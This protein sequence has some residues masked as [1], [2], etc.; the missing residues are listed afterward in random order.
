MSSLT[1]P[2]PLSAPLA[3]SGLF[4]LASLL[5]ACAQAPVP[6]SESDEISEPRGEDTGE[7]DVAES[8]DELFGNA[9]YGGDCSAGLKTFLDKIHF[10]GRVV[11]GSRAFEQCID[12]SLR[13]ATSS[14]YGGAFGEY[15][16]CN[17]DPYYGYSADV[18]RERV[19]EASRS[20]NDVF[21]YCTGGGGLASTN[22]GP[23]DTNNAE[24]LWWSGWLT[25]VYNSLGL[26]LCGPAQPAPCR[27]APDPW[28]YSQAA[29][30]VWHEA[31]H[32]HGYTHGANE[33]A[34]AL[35]A[36]GYSGD[37][38]WHF[39]VNT[40]PYIVGDCMS[41]VIDRSGM[42][43]G[44][45]ESCGSGMLKVVTG[46]GA[47]TCECVAD[48]RNIGTRSSGAFTHIV[49]A[50]NTSSATTTLDHPALNGNPSAK[51]QFTHVW[52]PPGGGTGYNGNR[53]I[54]WYN[55]ATARWVIQNSNGVSLPIG[56]GF[57]VR[58]GR[59]NVHRT[60]AANV[61]GHITY[62]DHP[63]ANGDPGAWVT[64]SPTPYAGAAGGN[65]NAHSI[66]VYYDPGVKKW[67]IY[68]QD[69]ATMPLDSGFTFDVETPAHRGLHF[70]HTSAAGNIS[71]HMTKLSSPFLDGNPNVR[72]LVTPDWTRG[73]VYDTHQFGV[74][75]DGSR[76]WIYNENGPSSGAAMPSGVAFHI[77]VLKDEI[78]RWVKVPEST[79]G[80]DTG[81]DVLSTDRV[82]I[83]GSGSI[84]SGTWFSPNVPPEGETG[85]PF[86]GNFPLNARI[87]SLIGRFTSDGYFYVGR[88]VVRGGPTSTQRLSV[89][90]NDDWPGNGNGYFQAEVRVFR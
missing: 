42:A 64:A 43:C 85:Y 32:Q 33:Q 77:E 10:Y 73:Q 26:P 90:T 39:Q 76:W 23:Y 61:S 3:L 6:E 4:A 71:G 68:N 2:T 70:V 69:F 78:Q 40:M 51:V 72:F 80:V 36:C 66:G 13:V 62:L 37:P 8:Q 88:D 83:H 48:P 9:S 44:N 86:N 55:Y 84:W 30:I 15:R 5:P 34:P 18:Q 20:A 45:M 25:D 11:A 49:T 50:A 54:A 28:P 35:T 38:T 16:Q 75:Y 59:G 65:V 29:G 89:R 53:P 46:Y 57:F 79:Y 21:M 12:H 19:L 82:R 56:T 81:I 58:A 52:N 22:L 41:D 17:G 47:S 14:A 7:E 63:L 67:T 60:S 1:R 87:Y 27:W 24:T 74:W 31:M